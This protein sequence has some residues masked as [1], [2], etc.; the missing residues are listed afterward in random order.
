[1]RT[2][3][4]A[5]DRASLHARFARLTPETRPAWGSMSA[6]RMLVHVTDGV[7]SAL[8]ELDVAPRSGP[9]AMWPLNNLVMFHLPWPK[10]APT[11]PELLARTPA[12]WSA[13]LEALRTALDRFGTRSLEGTWPRHAAFGHI[14]GDRWGRLLYRHTDHHLRQF[15]V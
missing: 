9:L 12:E 4:N 6:S 7:R 15:G 2:L 1:M 8:G 11:A 3:W 5:D 14:G 13:E 10:G